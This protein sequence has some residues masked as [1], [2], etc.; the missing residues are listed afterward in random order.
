MARRKPRSVRRGCSRSPTSSPRTWRGPSRRTSDSTPAARSRWSRQARNG[1]SPSGP[2]EA[3]CISVSPARGRIAIQATSASTS[4][5]GAS[6]NSRMLASRP[7]ASCARRT[8]SA[9]AR[10]FINRPMLEVVAQTA[11]AQE[12]KGSMRRN[13]CPGCSSL[14]SSRATSAIP[15]LAV[16]PSSERRVKWGTV[17]ASSS[18]TSV[19]RRESARGRRSST[20]VATVTATTAAIQP[21]GPDISATVPTARKIPTAEA[22]AV[23]TSARRLT[24]ARSPMPAL[25][26]ATVTPAICAASSPVGSRR[27]RATPSVAACGDSATTLT[28]PRAS[29]TNPSE[30]KNATPTSHQGAAAGSIGVATSGTSVTNATPP[31]IASARAQTVLPITPL[32]CAANGVRPLESTTAPPAVWVPEPCPTVAPRVS[33]IRGLRHVTRWRDGESASE[34]ARNDRERGNQHGGERDRADDAAPRQPERRPQANREQDHRPQR[35][36]EPGRDHERASRAGVRAAG[37]EPVVTEGQHDQRQGDDDR[38]RKRERREADDLAGFPRS[39]SRP[40]HRGPRAT[41][42]RRAGSSRTTRRCSPP[43]NVTTARTSQSID[44]SSSSVPQAG[45]NRIPAIPA[46][47]TI[48]KIGSERASTSISSSSRRATNTSVGRVSVRGTRRHHART[49]A[50]AASEPTRASPSAISPSLGWFLAQEASLARV[51]QLALGGRLTPGSLVPRRG[52]VDVARVG[53][54]IRRP[55]R[56]RRGVRARRADTGPCR[57]PR[58][59]RSPPGCRQR[60]TRRP[61]P[62]LRGRGRRPSPPA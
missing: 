23:A 45:V 12:T 30:R 13:T 2:V 9:R 7:G 56:L 57:S 15:A 26:S 59:P 41:R 36:A 40:R 16:A 32:I 31:A 8:A 14:I 17:G 49:R 27:K 48:A 62:R 18:G 24:A 35:A 6:S 50:C 53:E 29:S 44:S 4:A 52:S 28:R 3:T 21:I 25:A 19:R 1:E 47:T 38:E 37:P 34:E 33:P 55:R 60:S 54:R 20:A 22:L 42:R 51:I 5:S 58:P 43:M 46:R 39:A 10:R 61:P 11:A